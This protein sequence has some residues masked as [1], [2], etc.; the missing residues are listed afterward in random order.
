MMSSRN[1]EEPTKINKKTVD[2]SHHF[3]ETFI[4]NAW[5]SNESVSGPGSEINSPLVQDCIICIINFINQ[6]LNN[7]ETITISDIPCGDLNWINILLKEILEKTNC[8]NIKYYAYDIVEKIGEKF[9]MM[10]KIDN[11]T[12]T[13]NV[14]NAVTDISVKADIILCKEMFIHL[15]H[16]HIN[17][18]LQNFKNSG[19]TFL[20][21]S[22]S[23]NV[24]NKD[25][26][27]SCF[28]ECRH[29]SLMLPPFNLPEPLYY[30]S[31]Y[32]LWELEKI[33]N[34]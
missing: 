11:V 1:E 6:F 24:E 4:T 8:K 33:N 5:N 21:C 19:S 3:T 13:F 17:S 30:Y 16:S 20:V 23:G 34:I 32:K 7:K 18:C 25:I 31:C 10:D 26:E 15:S 12:Y 29:V 28:G 2:L 9:N 22:D 14:F 27:Y